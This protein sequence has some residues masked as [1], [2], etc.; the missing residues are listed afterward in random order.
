MLNI[1]H[2][3]AFFPALLPLLYIAFYQE[4]IEIERAT[5]EILTK[6]KEERDP[7]DL[8]KNEAYPKITKWPFSAF[9][10]SSITLELQ[11]SW[12]FLPH[13]MF[14]ECQSFVFYFLFSSICGH[15][16]I[17]SIIF[18]LYRLYQIIKDAIE[19]PVYSLRPS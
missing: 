18:F 4:H 5:Y 8:C 7:S 14:T 13:A 16:H 1:I 10:L 19:C 17:M 6:L 2:G 3:N 15:L 11:V 9:Y 12:F